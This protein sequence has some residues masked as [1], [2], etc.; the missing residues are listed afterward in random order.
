MVAIFISVFLLIYISLNVSSSTSFS[1]LLTDYIF[2]ILKEN[3]IYNNYT[4]EAIFT[5]FI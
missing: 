3:V 4:K 1:I 2:K 5:I